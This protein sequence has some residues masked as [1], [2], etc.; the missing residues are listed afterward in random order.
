MQLYLRASQVIEKE[1]NAA[2]VQSLFFL[3]A[4]PLFHR[5]KLLQILSRGLR[6]NVHEQ[7]AIS[8]QK[9]IAA[10]VPLQCKHARTRTLTM[11]LCTTSEQKIYPETKRKKYLRFGT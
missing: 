8:C 9:A 10:R 7:L 3:A 4:P 1:G 2:F 6:A 11:L 5:R